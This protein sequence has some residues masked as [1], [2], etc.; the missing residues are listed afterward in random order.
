MIKIHKNKE[1]NIPTNNSCCFFTHGLVA[2]NIDKGVERRPRHCTDSDEGPGTTN[3]YSY[4][5]SKPRKYYF[6]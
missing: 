3:N 1:L 2:E 5:R 4:T 6:S